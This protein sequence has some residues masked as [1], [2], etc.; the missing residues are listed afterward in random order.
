MANYL[1]QLVYT[2]GSK[3]STAE[4]PSRL[5]VEDYF[6][7][8]PRLVEIELSMSALALTQVMSKTI[9]LYT[10]RDPVLSLVHKWIFQG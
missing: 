10:S 8:L 5:P 9:A 4:G 3:I 2:P 6:T 7:L 1:Y